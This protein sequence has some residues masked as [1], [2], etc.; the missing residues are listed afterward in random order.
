MGRRRKTG[1]LRESEY[2]TGSIFVDSD[3]E[4]V[5]VYWCR[6]I[7]MFTSANHVRAACCLGYLETE[8]QAEQFVTAVA[9]GVR[10]NVF[11]DEP[12]RKWEGCKP[13]KKK[14]TPCLKQKHQ[15]K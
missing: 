10:F 11:A 4:L 8:E 15:A 7:N 1:M 2:A 14:R 3:D 9:D 6:D 12:P 13:L 5:T